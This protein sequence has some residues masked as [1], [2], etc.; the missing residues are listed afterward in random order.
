MAELVALLLCKASESTPVA[1]RIGQER[2]T[3]TAAEIHAKYADRK[4]RS[5]RQCR[6]AVIS[7][8]YGSDGR[9]YRKRSHNSFFAYP[10]S[11]SLC[12]FN[13]FTLTLRVV[14]SNKAFALQ[15]RSTNRR[16]E[17]S[18]DLTAAHC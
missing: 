7:L 16:L 9:R 12:P 3:F 8:I 6:H 1:N 15:T 5:C 14:D 18:V 11:P 17:I 10:R 4:C 13:I 2:P